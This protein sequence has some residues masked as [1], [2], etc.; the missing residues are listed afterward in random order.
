MAAWNIVRNVQAGAFQKPWGS[1]SDVPLYLEQASTVLVRMILS[2]PYYSYV[3]TSGTAVTWVAGDQFTG[4]T[5]SDYF[6]NRSE[7][8][9]DS[10]GQLSYQHYTRSKCW[11]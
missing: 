1:V 10:F 9:P 6:I 8:L 3:N 11:Y 4:L 7:C 5:S 2:D